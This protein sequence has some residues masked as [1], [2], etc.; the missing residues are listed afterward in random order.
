[1]RQMSLPIQLNEKELQVLLSRY[2]FNDNDFLHIKAIYQVVAPLV[3]ATAYYSI[4]QGKEKA[5]DFVSD[6]QYAPYEIGVVTLGNQVDELQNLYTKEGE[7]WK[8]YVVE[9]IALELLSKAYVILTEVIHKECGLWPRQYDFLG[10]RFPL[11]KMTDIFTYLGIKTAEVSY[12]EAYMLI[13][14]KSVVF[15]AS[16]TEDRKESACNICSGCGNVTCQNR[17]VSSERI[18]NYNYGYQRILGNMENPE[19]GRRKI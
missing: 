6:V 3:T 16:L 9:C 7:V 14:K 10:E 1:M 17:K 12:N 19:V 15:L 8:A 13:P 18:Q 2:H 11:E 4:E 5:L